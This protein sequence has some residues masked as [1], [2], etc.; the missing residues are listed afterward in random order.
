VGAGRDGF[1]PARLVS[2]NLGCRTRPI[3]SLAR[4]ADTR[5]WK[6]RCNRRG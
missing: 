2:V 6:P 4:E 5:G 3:A 1:R